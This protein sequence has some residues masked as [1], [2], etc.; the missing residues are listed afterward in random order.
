M[1]YCLFRGKSL[2]LSVVVLFTTANAET[3]PIVRPMSLPL[4]RP[5]PSCMIRHRCCSD[6]FLGDVPLDLR[7]RDTPRSFGSLPLTGDRCIIVVV[8]PFVL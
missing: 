6:R 8:S 2:L 7:L 4:E 1:S 5:R 3:S